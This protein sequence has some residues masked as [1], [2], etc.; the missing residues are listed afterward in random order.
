MIHHL[1]DLDLCFSA[2]VYFP[3]FCPV[4]L[5]SFSSTLLHACV[6]LVLPPSLFFSLPL[7][8]PTSLPPSL[9][10]SFLLTHLPSFPPSYPPYVTTF[11]SFP[12]P[13]DIEYSDDDNFHGDDEAEEISDIKL[14]GYDVYGTKGRSLTSSGK[15]TMTLSPPMDS[16]Q[17]V[18]NAVIGLPQIK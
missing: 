1:L 2:C 13:Q 6:T 17:K 15:T 9:L 11:A 4:V 3:V 16:F 10:P 5:F 12:R 8:L 14:T 18:K 7:S